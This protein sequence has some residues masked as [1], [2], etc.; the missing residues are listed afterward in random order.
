MK[1]PLI[2]ATEY[3]GTKTCSACGCQ[4]V[5]FDLSKANPVDDL[6]YEPLMQ[7]WK[8]HWRQGPRPKFTCDCHNPTL[9]EA[10]LDERAR[11]REEVIFTI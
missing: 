11:Q 5:M 8:R 9:V 7:S 1:G 2:R 3:R 6:C 4:W 10:Y